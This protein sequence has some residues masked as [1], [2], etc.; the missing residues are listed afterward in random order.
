MAHSPAVLV[1]R[2]I[3]TLEQAHE[4]IEKL[5]KFANGVTTWMYDSNLF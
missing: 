4:H 2:E 3:H 1:K 5:E